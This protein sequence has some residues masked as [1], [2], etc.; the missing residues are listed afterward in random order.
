[1]YVSDRSLQHCI[2]I[3]DILLHSCKSQSY[4]KSLQKFDVLP[5]SMGA[6]LS[7]R[8]SLACVKF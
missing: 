4:L 7:L 8:H 2:L 6:L 5:P 1:M 3:V